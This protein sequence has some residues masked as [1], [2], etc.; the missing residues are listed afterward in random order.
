MRPCEGFQS[1]QILTGHVLQNHI[2]VASRSQHAAHTACPPGAHLRMPQDSKG[3][4]RI[5]AG[6]KRYGFRFEDR[7]EYTRA[8]SWA[9]ASKKGAA[10]LLKKSLLARMIQR[11]ESG[12]TQMSYGSHVVALDHVV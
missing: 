3:G 9:E 8:K 7:C 1:T 11:H 12:W 6:F 4:K 10:K 2:E 5:G